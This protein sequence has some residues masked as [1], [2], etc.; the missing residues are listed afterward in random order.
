[1]VKPSE[2]NLDLE[3]LAA[4]FTRAWVDSSFRGAIIYFPER[5]AAEYHLGERE[6]YILSTGDISAVE[7]DDEEVMDKV[8][9][10]FDMTHMAGGE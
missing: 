2:Q 8:R 5:V 10:C 7:F 9:W 1:V 4:I 3:K 6:A